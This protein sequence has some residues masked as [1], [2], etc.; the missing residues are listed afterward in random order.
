MKKMFCLILAAILMFALSGCMYNKTI[1]DT[2]YGFDYAIIALPNGE[3]VEGKVQS[4]T[5]FKDGDQLQIKIDGKTY[6]AHAS[7]ATLIKK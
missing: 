3:I 1:L 2:T 6:L 4:W 7:N 5:D